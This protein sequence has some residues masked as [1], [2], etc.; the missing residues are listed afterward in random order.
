MKP[1]PKPRSDSDPDIE[2]AE[3]FLSW[4]DPDAVK[5]SF[6]TFDDD[7]YR[8]DKS[9]AQQRHGTFEQWKAE[10]TMLNRRGAGIFVTMNATDLWRADEEKYRGG[11][12]C[13]AG[14]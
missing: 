9:L 11:A 2:A 5:W 3:K 6:Q 14:S 1:K 10:L 13:G 8:A 4:L 12:S 7:A